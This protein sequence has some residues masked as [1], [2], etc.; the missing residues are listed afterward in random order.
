VEPPSGAAIGDLRAGARVVLLRQGG[1]YP[2]GA[3]RLSAWLP[4]GV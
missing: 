4:S 3:L 2:A 1:G